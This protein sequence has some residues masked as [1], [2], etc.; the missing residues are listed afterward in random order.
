MNP[1][2]KRFNRKDYVYGTDPNPFLK[3]HMDLFDKLNHIACFAEGEGRNAVYLASQGKKVTA[4]DYSTIGLKKMANL[5]KAMNVHVNTKLVDLVEESLD[6][7]IYDGAVMI[8]GHFSKKHQYDV[9]NKIVRSL[10]RGGLFLLEVY[11][12]GQL[13]YGTGGPRNIDFLYN[14]DQLLEWAKKQ[15]IIHFYNGEVDRM[16]GIAHT[17]K[18][19]V[20]QLILEKRVDIYPKG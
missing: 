17:G 19:K 2:D 20:I 4:Y 15:H 3:E 9:L 11:D 8:F 12:E 13:L 5:S 6:E 16:E 10:K 1:W 7:N 14:R 18:S